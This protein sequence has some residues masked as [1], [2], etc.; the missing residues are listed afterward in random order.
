VSVSSDVAAAC[1][2]S[3]ARAWRDCV[4]GCALVASNQLSAEVAW[5]SDTPI[6]IVA[7]L[8]FGLFNRVIGLGVGAAATD[9]DIET[10]AEAYGG[11][12]QLNWTVCV[13]PVSTPP[14]LGE[15]LLA[16][17]LRRGTDFAKVIRPTNSPP[18]ISTELRI[19]QVGAE[20]LDAFVGVNLA[21]WDVPGAF[22]PWFAGTVGRPGW[23]HYIGFDGDEPVTTGALHVSDGIGWLGFGATL[24]NHRNRGGQGAVMSRRIHDAGALGCTIVHTETGAETP[25][26]PNPSYRNMIRTGFEFAYLRPNYVSSPASK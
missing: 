3:E 16:H 14:D 1:E 9:D 23:N 2:L 4:E 11:R 15:R 6:P 19:E 7:A 24:P 13:S 21:A 26:S 12:S 25:D 10:I 17:G 18:E 20:W 8:D 22:S 5:V